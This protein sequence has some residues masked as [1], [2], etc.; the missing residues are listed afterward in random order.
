MHI[1]GVL[2]LIFALVFGVIAFGYM[3]SL[4]NDIAALAT[5]G[6]QP[7]VALFPTFGMILI[8]V[9]AIGGVILAVKLIFD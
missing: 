4:N 6:L 3:I 1:V 5:G 7:L 2:G 8:A 9:V